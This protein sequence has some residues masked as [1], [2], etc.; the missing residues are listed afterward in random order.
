MSGVAAVVA[1]SRARARRAST[2]AA[3]NRAAAR[4][5]DASYF[6]KHH[7]EQLFARHDTSGTGQLT[8]AQ[9]KLLL[10]EVNGEPLSQ[11]EVRYVL[12]LADQ[13]HDTLLSRDELVTAVTALRA[14]RRDQSVIAGVFAKFDTNGSG[15]LERPQLAALLREL[16]KGS[17]VSTEELE[18]VLR[19]ADADH[20]QAIDAHELSSAVALF[21]LH[22]TKQAEQC[23]RAKDSSRWLCRVPKQS[24][25]P[26]AL[27]DASIGAPSPTTVAT[28]TTEC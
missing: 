3:S 8:Q 11:P 1:G 21:Y 15:A 9:L 19:H 12:H 23:Q 4:L 16:N 5:E 18:W 20:N 22:T 13:D 17:D 25:F 2:A 24:E 6:G 28:A 10:E 7:M 27:R 26:G 14:L